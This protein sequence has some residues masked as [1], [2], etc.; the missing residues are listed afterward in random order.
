M[1]ATRLF[2]PSD[3]R[4]P[5]PKGSL[6]KSRLDGC[7]AEIKALLERSKAF[8]A[9]ILDVLDTTQVQIVRA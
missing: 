5:R 7:G 2:P 8:L 3:K 9:R 6:Y 4:N 1:T